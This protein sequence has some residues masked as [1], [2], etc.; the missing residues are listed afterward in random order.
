[1]PITGYGV[2][3]ATPTVFTSE[4]TG[5]S[6]H[7]S[8]VFDDGSTK[9]KQLS[10][11]IN[12]KSTGT[13]SRLVYWS[14]RN[15]QH[16][17]TQK[18]QDVDMGFHAITGSDQ[19]P[20][21]IALDL[22]RGDLVDLTK[23]TILSTNVDGP[24]NDIV[25]HLTEIFSDAI[26]AKATVYLWGQ[27]YSPTPDGIHDIHMNQ[28]NSGKASWTKDNGI[29]QDGS[30]MLKYPDGH[31]EAVFLAFASQATKTDDGGQPESNAE[32]FARLLSAPAQNDK[33]QTSGQQEVHTQQGHQHHHR[34]HHELSQYAIESRSKA[35]PI[36]VSF[37]TQDEGKSAGHVRVHDAEQKRDMKGWSVIDHHGG[38]H[39]L[40][41]AEA[42]AISNGDPVDLQDLS[43]RP[44]GGVVSLKDAEGKLVSEVVYS[45]FLKK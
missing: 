33:Q 42:H 30:F 14:N 12:V 20:N 26:T 10:S 44:E 19:G 7:G 24:D 18:L 39:G 3:V 23:G 31:W 25:D 2:W 35:S 36:T 21:G 5:K 11:A 43:L 22:L 28:G 34:K 1:M 8:L 45:K 38:S 32:T 27:Q 17:I 29:Y 16:A 9:Y 41:G 4:R 37:T 15:F 40:T 6:P 13:D